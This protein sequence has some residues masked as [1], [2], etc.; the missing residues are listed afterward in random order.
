MLPYLLHEFPTNTGFPNV[1]LCHILPL[2]SGVHKHLQHPHFL[3][4]RTPTCAWWRYFISLPAGFDRMLFSGYEPRKC[5]VRQWVRYLLKEKGA[6]LSQY[7]LQFIMVPRQ[8]WKFNETLSVFMY[9]IARLYRNKCKTDP[10]EI[11]G[12]TYVFMSCSCVCRRA[13]Y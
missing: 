3:F 12:R 2:V 4:L 8:L 1:P 6:W 7:F 9:K 13:K 5:T 10:G 11:T